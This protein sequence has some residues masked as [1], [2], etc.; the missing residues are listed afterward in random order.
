MAINPRLFQYLKIRLFQNL[1][2]RTR[3]FVGFGA[4]IALGA[5]VAGYG[6]LRLDAVGH[7]VNALAGITDNRAL[8]ITV[9][10]LAEKMRRLTLQYK[11]TGDEA[12]IKEFRQVQTEAQDALNLAAANSHSEERQRA[13]N[14]L[15][16]AVTVYHLTFDHL[17][18]NTKAINRDKAA[19]LEVGTDM[20]Q[21]LTRMIEAAQSKGDAV[22]TD[23]S[24]DIQHA[25]STVD[26]K[27]WR[28]LA[29]SD[30]KEFDAFGFAVD[31]AA[32]AMSST[33][34]H[35]NAESIQP[36]LAPLQTA[37]D[38]YS[39]SF[40]AIASHIIENNTY[41]E[42]TAVPQ[43]EGIQKALA[44]AADS[45]TR[46]TETVKTSTA[47]MV[48]EAS[49]MQIAV[50]I[51]GFLVGIGC[52]LVIGRSISR[53]VNGMTAAMLTLA[54]GDPKVEIPARDRRD[55]IG[56][57]AD[58]VQVFKDNLIETDRL[59][60]EQEAQKERA[61]ADRRRVMLDLADKFQSSVGGIAR[62][63]TTQAAALQ[64]TAQQMADSA[65]ATSS[66]STTVAAA[67]EQATQNVNTVA[68]ATEE[69]SSSMREIAKQVGHSTR[70]IGEARS[71]ANAT[72]EQVQGLAA[73]AQKIGE[74]VALI[75]DVASQ[76]NLLALNATIEAARA[77][78]AGKG[79]AVVA[80]EVKTLANQTAKAT[81]EIAAQIAAIQ[82]AT[83]V[84]VQSIKGITETI[85]TVND[86][87]ASIAAA[88]EQQGAATQEIARNVAEAARGTAEVTTNISGVSEA[89]HETRAAA[90]QMLSSANDLSSNGE[91]LKS[92]VE[93]F[94]D[95]VRAA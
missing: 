43:V 61:E 41:Y 72:N 89:T 45:I 79:F 82:Q 47:A 10:Q 12:A 13:Y 62:G 91:T 75:N 1:K 66:R 69:L 36:F 54:G 11:A 8:T 74:V 4:V 34:N 39:D 14:D 68:V 86:T 16:A 37:L 59:R 85:A 67:S 73:A 22:L 35:P 29:S 70:V 2:I 40:N 18:N 26:Q 65:E 55:E 30:P 60:A 38:N 77:G 6:V 76:T 33:A 87:A 3:I 78:D 21:R 46:D 9:N 25:L 81:D 44:A 27:A 64:T 48:K 17:V 94:L 20:A 32:M 83:M 58:A 19:L 56:V 53:P 7:Q 90:G 28:F 24:R 51:M 84:S 63:L 71:Q 80:S 5:L 52:A 42:K 31:L 95:E 23:G 92:Q 88:I 50:A 49:T 93:R 57:M 15:T